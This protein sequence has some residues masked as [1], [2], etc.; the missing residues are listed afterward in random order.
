MLSPHCGATNAKLRL[1][2]A[3][4]L[5]ESVTQPRIRAGAEVRTWV[6]GDGFML[7]D[8]FEHEVYWEPALDEPDDDLGNARAVLLLDVPHVDTLSPAQQAN[9]CPTTHPDAVA[10]TGGRARRA[11]GGKSRKS[12]QSVAV[13]PLGSVRAA[14]ER[15]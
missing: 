6:E 2:H 8:S 12:K 3:L 14:S 5:P 7:D 1:H 13:D 9:L 4:H 15:S 10:A 11:G